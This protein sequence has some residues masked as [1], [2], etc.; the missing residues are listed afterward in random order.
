MNL[1]KI[2][3]LLTTNSKGDYNTNLIANNLTP[4]NKST[5]NI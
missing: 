5:N 1:D 2:E 4:E 3:L